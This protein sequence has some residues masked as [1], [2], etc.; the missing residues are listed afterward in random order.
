MLQH[1]TKFRE[2]WEQREVKTL[3]TDRDQKIKT[4]EE[5]KVWLAENQER[6]KDEEEKFADTT[7]KELEED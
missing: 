6:I 3:E 2:I 4:Q 5:D 7:L 1:V